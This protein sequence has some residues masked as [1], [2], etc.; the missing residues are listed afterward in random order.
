MRPKKD[1]FWRGDSREIA[2]AWPKPVRA[3]LGDELMRVQLG[4]NPFHG[5]PLPEIGSGVCEIRL[6]SS[7]E[8]YRAVYIASL[9]IKVYVLH[10]FQKKSKRGIAMPKLDRELAIQR[11]KALCVE[12]AARQQPPRR[13]Q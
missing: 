13:T 7:G 6:A 2:R 4:A 3:R 12:L 9:G 8:A 1:V 11:F 5:A 10:A